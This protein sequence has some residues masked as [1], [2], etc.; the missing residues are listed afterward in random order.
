M[1]IEYS[2]EEGQIKLRSTEKPKR[3]CWYL[4]IIVLLLTIGLGIWLFIRGYF[5]PADS[6]SPQAIS[7]R[8]KLNEQAHT[9]ERQNNKITELENELGITRREKAIQKTANEE[10]NKQLLLA[11]Q[12][13]SEAEEQLL[14]YGNILSTQDL[15]AGLRIQHF[16]MK[17]IKV[18]NEGQKLESD[19]H[20]RYS[21]VLSNIRNDDTTTVTGNFEIILTGRQ[22]G[23][24]VSLSHTDL[25]LKENQVV[26]RFSL[27]YY[28]SLDGEILLPEGFSP[29][30]V[31][32]VVKPK[33]GKALDESHK[34]RTLLAKE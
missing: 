31:Q 28:K 33:E 13:L 32:V 30:K 1:A 17:I 14:L 7:L 5:I 20:Y 26:S 4:L 22:A 34:W 9:L 10:L 16:G 12:K 24:T 2:Y 8:G 19:R 18:D 25:P 21:L 29:K 27:K 3:R 6:D 23:K 15:E 11:E